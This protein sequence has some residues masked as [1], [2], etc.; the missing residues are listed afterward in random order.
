[1][2]PILR[3]IIPQINTIVHTY[4]KYIL[5]KPT[6]TEYLRLFMNLYFYFV[7]TLD[8]G[9]ILWG[10]FIKGEVQLLEGGYSRVGE[11]M[12]LG[13]VLG[14]VCVWLDLGAVAHSVFVEHLDW[15]YC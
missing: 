9:E 4:N 13:W 12:G 7:F 1:M 14:E 2:K 6:Y 10:G 5:I 3:N 11:M 15:V 8:L